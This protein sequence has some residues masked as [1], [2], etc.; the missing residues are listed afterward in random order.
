MYIRL[1]LNELKISLRDL[2]YVLNHHFMKR[3]PPARRPFDLEAK[4]LKT[5]TIQWNTSIYKNLTAIYPVY[6]TAFGVRDYS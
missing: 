3:G 5:L 6:S 4:Y 2:T 1:C